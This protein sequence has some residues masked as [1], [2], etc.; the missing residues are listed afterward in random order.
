MTANTDMHH[1][2]INLSFRA[3]ALF[4]LRTEQQLKHWF[5]TQSI[6]KDLKDGERDKFDRHYKEFFC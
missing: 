3:M 1:K 5:D 6:S 2:V 4:F